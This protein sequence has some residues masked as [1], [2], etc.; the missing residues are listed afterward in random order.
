MAHMLNE[1]IALR[2]YKGKFLYPLNPHN[3]KKNSIVYLM[4]PNIKSSIKVINNESAY[5]SN[6]YFESYYLEKNVDIVLQKPTNE[7]VGYINEQTVPYDPVLS[8]EITNHAPFVLNESEFSTSNDEFD[9]RSFSDMYVDKVLNEEFGKHDYSALFKK[10]LFNVRL[11]NQKDVLLLYEKIKQACPHIKNT[12]VTNQMYKNRNL[13]YDWS[14]YTESFFKHFPIKEYKGERALDLLYN[15]FSRYTSSNYFTAT[16]YSAETLVIPIDDWCKGQS[17]PLDYKTNITP[18]SMIWRMLK[19]RPDMIKDLFNGKLVLFTCGNYFFIFNPKYFELSKDYPKLTKLFTDLAKKATTGSDEGI[20]AET[21]TGDSKKAILLHL[22]D[23]LEQD[24]NIKINNL[25]GGT[26]QMTKDDLK[27]SGLLDSP[28]ISND[29]EVKKAALLDK[30]EQIADKSTNIADAEKQLENPGS[31]EDDE[32]IKSILID[33]QSDDGGIKMSAARKSRMQ[34]ARE[35]IL[36][37][38]I[39]GKSI[40][41][42]LNEFKRNDD[43]PETAIPID[44]IDDHWKHVKFVNFNKTY[45][46]R[47]DIVAMFMHFQDIPHPM[48]VVSLTAENTS[49]SED[50]KE[51]WTCVYEDVEDGKRHT[52]TLDIP[53]IIGDRFM[54][55]RGNEKTLIG[56]LMLL[57][58]IKTDEDTVQIVSNYNKIFIRRKSPNGLS[59]STPI[60]NKLVKTLDKYT[61]TGIKVIPGDNKKICSRYELPM[62]FIDIAS[63]YARIKFKDDSYISFNMDELSKIPFD[64]S[65]LPDKEKKLP[66]KDLCNK[67]L[68]VYVSKGQREPISGPFDLYLLEKIKEHDNASADFTK[69]YE[70]AAVSRRLMYAEASIMSTTIPVAVI[71]SYNVGLQTLLSKLGVKYEFSETRPS[72]DKTYIRFEDGYLAWS[73]TT[74]A[75]NI[76]LN[77]LMECDFSSYS[78]KNMNEKEMWLDMLDNFGGRIKADGL[79]NFYDLMFDPITK[80]ICRTLNI[81]DDYIESLLYA[82]NLLTDNKYNK[83]TDITGNRLRTNEVIVGHLYLVLS[84]AFGAYRNM[85]KRQKGKASFSAD[86]A[87]V[88]NS[89]LNHDQTASDLSTLTPLLEAEAANKVTFKGL[90]GMNSDRAFS[91]DKRTYDKSMIG[92]LGLSTGFAGTVGINRQT[93]IDA[94]VVNKRGFMSTRKLDELDNTRT[95]TVMEALSPLAVNHDDPIRTCMAFT[96][97]VQHQMLTKRSMPNLVT[98]GADEAL[99][100]LTSNKFAYKFSGKRGTVVELTDEYMVV[101]DEDTKECD[102]IDLREII[103]KNSDGGFYVTTKLDAIV[104]KGDKI[105]NNQILAYNKACYSNAVGNDG[106]KLDNISY[107][108]GTLAKV[109]IMD[110]DLG[111]EDS[112][113]VDDTISEALASEFVVQKEI[114]FDK[115]TNIYNMMKVGDHVDEGDPLLVFQDAYDELEANELLMTLAKDNDLLSDLGRKQINSKNTGTIQDI[116]IYRTV[117]IDQLSPTLQEI[118]KKYDAKINKLKSVMDKY[119]VDKKYT[120]ES[121]GKLPAEG[122]LQDVEGV[123]IEFYI[124]VYDKFGIGDKLVFSQALKGVNSMII[125]KG[126]EAYTDFRPNEHINAFLTVDGVMARMVTSAQSLGL[127]NK[128][129][130][131]L[132]RKCQDELG[133]K[134]R[135]IQD[136]LR[137]KNNS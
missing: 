88:I 60:I 93:T 117:E 92:I 58:I 109:A 71:I 136:I 3:K 5:M 110:T 74:S 76:V 53:L 12:Y 78:M 42:L 83:H 4:T 104:K 113:V 85:V 89:I 128:L 57:P 112:C 27:D 80:E 14:Y 31:K 63:L 118:C 54:K 121:T 84:K 70:S 82:S 120:L 86:K 25:T 75:Q 30:L 17:N 87:A 6:I 95:F 132:A 7:S 81:P 39:N 111:Y 19:I 91:I 100:Y 66:E 65:K 29:V 137:D 135:P 67:Y 61:G 90:S 103:Q 134:W 23:K 94:G 49:T 21:L 125:E 34:K 8:Y 106:S 77:G 122:K 105:S 26:S 20:E 123:R 64:R 36:G 47:P 102:Y 129:L 43:I 45:D 68:G 37:K 41:E 97:T 124:K 62:E 10:M 38:E 130:I 22:V 107:N 28:E 108:I 114:N 73:D 35:E 50:Y 2:L 24:G 133:I 18:I 101:R 51:T 48:N 131:E 96:Q 55:L 16:G 59:K 33:L 127:M 46:L 13:Y 126:K 115:N 79:D 32:K 52:M 116:K 98:T 44:S 99:P 1:L 72:R 9:I 40:K 69:L 56:Q 15:F 119:N 11:R